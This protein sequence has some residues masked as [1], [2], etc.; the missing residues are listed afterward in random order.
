MANGKIR[1]GKQSGGELALVFPDGVENIQVIVPESGELA[2]KQYLDGLQVAL[3]DLQ[4]NVGI[5]TSIE[6]W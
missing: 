6:E 3:S 5:I 2:T 4:E 1:F